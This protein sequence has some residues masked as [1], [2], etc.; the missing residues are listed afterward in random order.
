MSTGHGD[1][2][3]G[4]E[5]EPE[6]AQ[7]VQDYLHASGYRTEWVADGAHVMAAYARVLPALVLLDLMLSMKI[8]MD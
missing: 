4:V 6:L 7:L 2:I 3:L 1:C 8:C 5:D